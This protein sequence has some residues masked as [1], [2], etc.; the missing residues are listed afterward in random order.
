MRRTNERSMTL[1]GTN[2]I[3]S[4]GGTRTSTLRA[5]QFAVILVPGSRHCVCVC[6]CAVRK[7]ASNRMKNQRASEREFIRLCHMRDA[8][9]CE[10]AHSLTK[11]IDCANEVVPPSIEYSD[12]GLWSV[13]FANIAII[14][15]FRFSFF[16][17]LRRRRRRRT[18]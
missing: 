6:V 2:V 10:A 14:L 1:T 5:T 7:S 13:T 9:M 11:L 12:I 8:N 17:A 15:C 18:L 16:A 3:P 4:Y